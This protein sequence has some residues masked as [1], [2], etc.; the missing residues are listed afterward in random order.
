MDDKNKGVLCGDPRRLLERIAEGLF[1][2]R[3][4]RV[5]GGAVLRRVQDLA[6]DAA[7]LEVALETSRYAPPKIDE[8]TGQTQD[9]VERTMRLIVEHTALVDRWTEAELELASEH[10]ASS[11]SRGAGEGA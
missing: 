7:R 11:V 10:R 9:A 2:E 6:V 4:G 3:K 5:T 8:K 1:P